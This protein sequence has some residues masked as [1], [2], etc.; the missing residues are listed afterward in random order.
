VTNSTGQDQR[1]SRPRAAAFALALAFAVLAAGCGSSNGGSSLTTSSRAPLA[2][3]L[4]YTRCMRSHGVHDYPDP[5]IPPGG[6]VTVRINGGPGSDLN[7]SNPAFETASHACRKLSLGGQQAPTASTEQIAAEVRW[8][9]CLR[10]H[11]VPAFPD[12][13]S[14]GAIDSGKFDPTSP[15]FR[16]ASAACKAREP[17]GPITAVPGAP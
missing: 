1:R 14:N 3:A 4:A 10:A 5:S 8:A 11:G 7:R 2:M 9:R 6:G 12:P 15:A 13:N 17:S 16:R